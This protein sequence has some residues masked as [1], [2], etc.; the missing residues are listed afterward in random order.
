MRLLAQYTDVLI[1]RKT[2]NNTGCPE[3]Y[4]W[5]SGGTIDSCSIGFNL[6]VKVLQLVNC[7]FDSVRPSGR[8]EQRYAHMCTAYQVTIV[9]TV[10]NPGW[11][12][13]VRHIPVP[14][15]NIH[16]FLCGHARRLKEVARVHPVRP[17]TSQQH[18]SDE[19]GS[20]AARIRNPPPKL[21]LRCGNTAFA[22]ARCTMGAVSRVL[23]ALSTLYTYQPSKF[24]GTVCTT[25]L[26]R[27]SPI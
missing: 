11:V 15:H 8:R 26:L 4:T 9:Y 17:A 21:P 5:K 7:K 10:Q 23:G 18:T 24:Q 12:I 1:S 27:T 25:T 13:A 6:R 20:K 19:Y 3:L 22:V 16:L 14:C 2:G